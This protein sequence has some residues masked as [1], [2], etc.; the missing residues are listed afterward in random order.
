M[1]NDNYPQNTADY[2]EEFIFILAGSVFG[3]EEIRL[4]LKDGNMLSFVRHR[5]SFVKGI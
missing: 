4:F 1:M 2:D 5:L 3:L